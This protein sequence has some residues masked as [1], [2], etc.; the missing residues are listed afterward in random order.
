MRLNANGT[1][2]IVNWQYETIENPSEVNRSQHPTVDQTTIFVKRA[3]TKEVLDT[4][5]VVRFHT[6]P[7]N[8]DKARKFALTKVLKALYP[9][10]KELRAPFWEA[11]KHRNDTNHV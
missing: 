4:A 7:P 2:V 8:K 1:D 6:D 11:Y 3:D 10:N 5:V 9:N